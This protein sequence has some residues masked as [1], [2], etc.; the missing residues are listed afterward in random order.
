MPSGRSP[1]VSYRSNAARH[2]GSAATISAT[3]AAARST[4][5]FRAW[6]NTTAAATS[7]SGKSRGA[8]GGRLLLGVG[9]RLDP[10]AAPVAGRHALEPPELGERLGV[11]VDAQVEDALVRKGVLA[12]H[13]DEARGL[14]PAEVAAGRL[15]R[16]ERGEEA[17]RERPRGCG[18]RIGHRGPDLGRAQHVA[19]HAEPGALEVAAVGDAA[20]TR[21]RGRPSFAVDEGDL[22]NVAQLV[23]REELVE[24]LA[25]RLPALHRCKAARAVSALRERLRRDDADPRQ[26]PRACG[27]GVERAGLHRDAQLLALGIPRDERVGH[28][29]TLAPRRRPYGK[30]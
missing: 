28:A 11:V 22:P 7:S 19:L 18:E 12:R 1:S 2:S 14:P 17:L 15:R 23:L 27:A 21:V 5:P 3:S 10:V 6:A 8:R 26:R 30:P 20:R 16:V 9:T 13:D 29:A 25:W 24:G 4:S